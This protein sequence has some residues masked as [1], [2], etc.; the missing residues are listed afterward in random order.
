MAA[1]DPGKLPAVRAQIWT[2]IQAAQLDHDLAWRRGPRRRRFDDFLLH[3]DGW[4]C[5][6]KDAQIRDGLH[7]LG[8]GAGRRP[9]GSDLVLAMLRAQADLV[10][11]ARPDCRAL[12]EALGLAEDGYRRRRA[13][14]DRA[15]GAAPGRWSEAMELRGWQADARA[16]RRRRRARRR[17]ANRSS[18][19][20]VRGR[21]RWCPGWRAT[22]DELDDVLHALDGGLRAGRAERLARSAALVNVLPTGRNFYSVDPKAVPV[23]AR[24]GGRR[25][26]WPTRCSPATAPTPATGRASVGL[27][28]WGTA[29]MRTRA[30]T[31]PRCWPCSGCRPVWDD[32]RGGS[33]AWRSSRSTELGRPRIDVTVRISGFFRDAFPHVVDMLD[34][35]VGWSPASTSPPT[36]NLRPR[37]RR[38]R[39]GRHGDLR[40]A[41]TARLRLQARRLRRRACCR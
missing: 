10:G 2:L 34:D 37:P 13:E 25:S 27:S 19:P 14:V 32:A 15:G 38:G 1:L 39:P 17:P 30:T 33:R 20:A 36:G 9:S 11:Q 35:A 23:P 4:L 7:V 24:L 3:V 12:R 6:V 40:R 41:T 31:S 21:P 18:A 29:A 26:R 22:T 8:G 5:E 16:G 28:V